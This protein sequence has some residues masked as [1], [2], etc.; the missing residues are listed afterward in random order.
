[1]HDNLI[2]SMENLGLWG[3]LQVRSCIIQLVLLV[4]LKFMLCFSLVI[5]VPFLHNMLVALWFIDLFLVKGKVMIPVS[6]F[7]LLRSFIGYICHFHIALQN[8]ILLR[9]DICALFL[10]KA[11]CEACVQVFGQCSYSCIEWSVPSTDIF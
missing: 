8:L 10:M 9:A 11:L 4:L 2:F 3:A 6:Y 5:P 1:M 7:M